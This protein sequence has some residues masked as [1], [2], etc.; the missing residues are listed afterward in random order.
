[1]VPTD[2]PACTIT[3]FRPDLVGTPETQWNISVVQVFVE[4]YTA[5]NPHLDQGTIKELF[6]GHLRY[7]CDRYKYG[8]SGMPALRSR[9]RILDRGRRQRNLWTRRICAATMLPEL[10]H[11]LPIL[12][13]LGPRGMS[14]DESDHRP[15][16]EVQY[17][18]LE[19]RWR[20]PA[21]VP[22]LRLYDRVYS[23]SPLA[24]TDDPHERNRVQYFKMSD[25][26]SPA[27]GLPYNA[28]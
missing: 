25:H 11:H 22:W 12:R 13:D 9:Q 5:I 8:S 3:S 28:Y 17:R 24:S 7:L 10:N 26:V 4:H 20:H 21:L 15:Y 1:Y 18:I 2:G 27:R 6:T 19:K 16:Q 23:A 14:S